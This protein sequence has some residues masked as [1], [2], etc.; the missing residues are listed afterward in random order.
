[1]FEQGGEDVGEVMLDTVM[2]DSQARRVP[3]RPEIRMQVGDDG[4][5]SDA[6]EAL[7]VGQRLLE[8][9]EVAVVVEVAQELARD[10]VSV[11]VDGDRVLEL[12]SQGDERAVTPQA[13][14]HGL[15]VGDIPARTPDEERAVWFENAEGKGGYYTADGKNIRKAFLRSPLEF[16]RITSGFS[17]ARFHPILQKWRAHNGIDY[18]APSG[19]RV[20][21]T[22]DGTVEFAGNQGGYGRVV[23]LRHQSRY[24]TLYGHLSGFAAG[25]RKGVRIAQGDVIGYVGATGWAT[26]PHLHYEFRIN[27]VNQNPLAVALPSAPPLDAQ[28]LGRF[29][30]LVLPQLVRLDL[31]K[32]N[33]LALL[34]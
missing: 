17:S 15:R 34:D 8:I 29:R 14:G 4:L 27:E 28:Q 26:G 11:A 16:S 3:G 9:A 13:F 2:G 19:T 24:T 5:G 23:I 30:A 18:G 21:S 25:I 22:G 20:K 32:G 33:N 7:E 6:E 31:I 10:D 1:V 12:A